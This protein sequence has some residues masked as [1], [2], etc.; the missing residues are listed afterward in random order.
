MSDDEQTGKCV[1][2]MPAK[3]HL[4][5]INM[6]KV[7]IIKPNDMF[8]IYTRETFC[9]PNSETLTQQQTSASDVTLSMLVSK[10]TNQPTVRLYIFI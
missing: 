5:V 2:I 1:Y 6:N 9:K 8:Y 10:K 3:E 7:D 4:F